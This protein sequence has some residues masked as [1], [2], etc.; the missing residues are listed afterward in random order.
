M[1]QDTIDNI[2]KGDLDAYDAV[3]RQ[4]RGMLL[5]YAAHR[6]ADADA[7]QEIVQLTFNRNAP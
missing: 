2:L 6:L 3:V 1:K 7:A 4:Y 5:G